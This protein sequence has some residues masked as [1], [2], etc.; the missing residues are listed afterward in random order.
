MGSLPNEVL[1]RLAFRKNT[2]LI[3]TREFQH[4]LELL[5]DGQDFFGIKYPMA[6]R[7]APGFGRYFCPRKKNRPGVWVGQSHRG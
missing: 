7:Y 1:T 4:I 3:S 6:G 5:H 2:L